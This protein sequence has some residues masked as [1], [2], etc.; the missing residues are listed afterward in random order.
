MAVKEDQIN[1]QKSI[2][3]HM[4][5]TRRGIPFIVILMALQHF[6]NYVIP[7]LDLLRKIG[8]IMVVVNSIGLVFLKGIFPGGIEE[9]EATVV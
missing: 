6:R 1:W 4:G 3:S 5:R 2:Q 8:L 9:R 7:V